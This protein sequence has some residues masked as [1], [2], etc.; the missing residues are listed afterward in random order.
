MFYKIRANSDHPVNQWMTP[1]F[2]PSRLTR[3]AVAAHGQ[4]VTLRRAKTSKFARTF[5]S[6]LWNGLTSAVFDEVDLVRFESR[7]NSFLLLN[8]LDF[9][10]LFLFFLL[11]LFRIGLTE[12]TSVC[13][14]HVPL[15]RVVPCLSC[16]NNNN[17]GELHHAFTA[18]ASWSPSFSD[19]PWFGS[20]G[21]RAFFPLNQLANR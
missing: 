1:P 4:S 17:K 10:S 11:I 3:G 12:G 9:Y 19:G 7:V 20:G 13:M 21:I 5:V 15:S 8:W 14:G 16:N 6:R 18:S 2:V